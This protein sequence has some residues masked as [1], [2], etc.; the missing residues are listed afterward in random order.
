M[1]EAIPS[2]AAELVASSREEFEDA[3][4]EFS[5]SVQIVSRPSGQSPP[6]ARRSESGPAPRHRRSPRGVD[7][8]RPSRYSARHRYGVRAPST[9]R[10]PGTAS[11]AAPGPAQHQ[12]RAAR[13]DCLS[14]AAESAPDCSLR[15]PH[16]GLSPALGRRERAVLGDELPQSRDKTPRSGYRPG[17]TVGPRRRRIRRVGSYCGNLGPPNF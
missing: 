6:L 17:R 7:A 9:E 1:R 16:G 10:E 3:S 11:S 14:E 4:S 8:C 15:R 13:L 12:V 5:R 2:T